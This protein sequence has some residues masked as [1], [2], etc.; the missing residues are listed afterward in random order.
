MGN[1]KQTAASRKRENN[2]D[3]NDKND[4]HNNHNK[5]HRHPLELTFSEAWLGAILAILLGYFAAQIQELFVEFAFSKDGG[6]V[7]GLPQSSSTTRQQLPVLAEDVRGVAR[8]E[9]NWD[10][11][12]DDDLISNR[13]QQ[14]Q[15]FVNRNEPF[16]CRHCMKQESLKWWKEDSNLL[17]VIGPDTILPVRVANNSNNNNN[18]KKKNPSD[19]NNATITHFQRMAAPG[20]SGSSSSAYQER[21]MTAYEFLS[22]YERHNGQHPTTKGEHWYAAQVD[23]VTTL[24]G[25]LLKFAL[26]SSPPGSLL[27]AVGPLPTNK[28]FTLYMGSGT[29]KTQLHYDSLENIVCLASG[30]SKTFDLY[31]PA[32]SSK[33]LYIDRSKHGNG[34]PIIGGSVGGGDYDDDYPMAKYALASHISL[35]PGDCLYLPVYWYHTVTSPADRSI[36]INFWRSP[37]KTKMRILESIFCG[38][39]NFGAQAKCG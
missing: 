13:I 1:K 17:P 20:T 38:K 37:D 26:A 2:N 39:E 3:N 11:I 28:P 6:G 31:D 12:D 36:S 30:S 14:V 5:H 18:K 24:G 33:F 21:N 10:M 32:T 25:G 7:G 15:D 35:G 34:S 27:E 9:F 4:K 22:N 8:I 29:R 16:V 19:N 23:M